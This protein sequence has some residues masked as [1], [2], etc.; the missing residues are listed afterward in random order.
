MRPGNELKQVYKDA[1][2]FLQEKPKFEYLVNHLPKNL[3]YCTGLDFRETPL[4]LSPKNMAT[5]KKGMVFCLNLAFQDVPLSEEDRTAISEK[6]STKK[7]EKFSLLLADMIAVTADTPDLLTKLGKNLTDVAYN[8]NDQEDSDASSDEDD[9]EDE[10]ASDDDAPKAPKGDRQ[11]AK[12]LAKEGEATGRKSSRLAKEQAKTEAVSEGAAQRLL[13][14]IKLMKRRNEERLRELARANRNKDEEDGKSA[15]DE[16]EAYKRTRDYPDNVQ[17]NQVKVDMANQCVLL[18]ICGNAVPFHI[19]T[20][21]NVVMPDADNVT[22]L[23]INFYTAGIA[24]GKDAPANMVKLVQKY[25]PYASF[26]REMTF[27]SLDGHNLTLAFRQIS[28]LRKRE[29]Q[30]EITLQEEANLVKQ[31]KLVRTKNERVPRLADLT[32]RPV[33][34][35]RKTQG[36]LEAH[37]N[38]LR[39]ISSRNEIVDIMYANIKY[40]IFQPCENEIMVLVHFHLKNPIM[41][42][43]KRQNDVQFFTEVVDAS[44]AVDNSRRSMYD[45]DEMDDE[46]RERQLRKRL[47]QAFKEFCKK[48]DAVA[49]K[50]GYNLEFEIPYRDLG[51]TGNP[52]KEMVKI[53]PTLSCLVNLTETPFF[54]VDLEQV[55]HVHFERV[56][57]MSKAFDMVLVNKDFKKPAWRVDMIPNEDKDAI[58]EWL[59]DMEL[60]FTEGPMNLNWKQIMATILEDDRFYMDTEDDEVTKKPAG[61]EFLRMYGDDDEEEEED[62]DADD[63]E[64]DE[65]KIESEESE[66][67]D[68]EEDFDSEDDEDDFDEDAEDELE[69]QGLDWDEMEVKAAAE[70]KRKRVLDEDMDNDRPLQRASKKNRRR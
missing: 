56:T 53:M 68:S 19:S 16:L 29:R 10:D 25:A 6:S 20:I 43:K 28:E 48:V 58:Q 12:K 63:S 46:Q 54:V 31:E 35:G 22:L 17:P 60:T 5:F 4:L 7:L 65:E 11:L 41:I 13:K 33:F 26:V 9:D 47:N 24:L 55:D 34:A 62:P 27:R 69:E 64:F 50:N 8:I 52:H 61:W 1:V 57:Y 44:Q 15:V 32:M 39:F 49:K 2:K 37:S 40:A 70:D 42:G 51:F 21:K 14:Q 23:R 18:P 3:G 66:A 36:N 38:G 67:S 59:T 45:P 30:K